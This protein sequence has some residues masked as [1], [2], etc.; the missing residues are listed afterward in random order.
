MNILL[1]IVIAVIGVAIAIKSEA[2]LNAFGSI[3][4]FEKYL[5][6][7]GGTRLGYK[8]IGILAFF[9]GVMIATNVIGDFMLWILS[10]LISA[11]RGG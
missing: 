9:I 2:M 7:E 3:A 6:T 4:F 11:G 5:G 8:L 1:G 10:P